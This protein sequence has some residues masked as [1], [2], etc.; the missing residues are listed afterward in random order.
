MRLGRIADLV[1]PHDLVVLASYPAEN[2]HRILIGNAGSEFWPGFIKS[3]EFLD[4][5]PDPLDRWSKRIG[6]AVAKETG[7]DVVFPFD[8]PPYPPFLNWAA[9]SGQVHSSPISISI[10]REF[11]LWHAYRFALELDELT[12]GS[13][14]VQHQASPCDNCESKPCLS[15]CP[16]N[17]FR[18]GIYRVNEC[19]EYVRANNQSVCRTNGCDARR[20][21]PVRPDLQYQADHAQF[22]MKAFLG[23]S[24]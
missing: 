16:V 14:A 18:S 11:G 2:V 15:A 9:E 12:E 5:N 21:C 13:T 17:A 19:M 4:G 24:L 22:H 3:A 10:H 7:A 6:L 20:A 8:G 23:Q 1:R